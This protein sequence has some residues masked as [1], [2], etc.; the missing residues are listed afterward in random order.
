MSDLPARPGRI[1]HVARSTLS[2]YIGQFITM[3]AWFLLTPFILHTLGTAQYGLWILISSIVAYGALLDF[4]IAS[5]VTKYVSEYEAT[6]QPQ[7]AQALLTTAL[8]IHSALGLLV[9]LLSVILAPILPRFFNIPPHEEQ[10]TVWLIRLSGATVGLSIPGAI[11]PSILRGLQRFDLI[12]ALNVTSTFLTVVGTVVVLLFGGGVI[13]IVLVSMGVLVIMQLPYLWVIRRIASDLRLGAWDASKGKVQEMMSFS[14]PVFAIH[15]GGQLETKTDDLVIGAFLP[16]RAIA[17]FDI[18]RKLASIPLLITEQF[19]KL[20][21]PLASELSAENDRAG[22]ASLYT[23]STR[24]TLAIFLPFACILAILA[25]PLLAAWVGPAYEEYAG[26]VLIIVLA[27]LIDTSQWPA[28][29]IL[30]GMGRHRPLGWLSLGTGIANLVLSVTLVQR[31]GLT[32]VAVG[33]LIPTT[34]VC[35]GFILPYTTS[36]L[37]VSAPV[38]LRQMLLP[39]FLPAFPMVVVLVLLRNLVFHASLYSLAAIV[40]VGLLV[41]VLSYAAVSAGDFER[42]LYRSAVSGTRQHAT[43]WLK[44]AQL[45]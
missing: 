26:L 18:A 28:G 23:I 40:L 4:G 44:R 12:N 2:N 17:P 16:V 39:A 21:L 9:I 43:A 36:V 30:Q 27:G 25:G 31:F 34:I 20:L 19:L 15:L 14:L 42:R 7:E 22:L 32:G 11:A 5:A 8:V 45:S 1:S 24:L 3:A 35:L 37:N 33:T 13:G 29:L 6:K 41:Y 38:A 10:I